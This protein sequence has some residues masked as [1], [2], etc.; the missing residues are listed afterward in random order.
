MFTI[1]RHYERVLHREAVPLA[2]SAAYPNVNGD[3]K[4]DAGSQEL[5]EQDK[6][7]IRRRRASFEEQA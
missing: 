1:Q 5:K 2:A 4:A 3:E 7:K 6:N